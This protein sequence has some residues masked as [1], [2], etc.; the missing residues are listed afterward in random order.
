MPKEAKQ[1]SKLLYILKALYEQTDEQKCLSCSQII[2]YL[3]ENDIIVERKTVISDIACM[4]DFGLDIGV[5]KGKDISGYYL[6]SR[7][8]ELPELKIITEAI[9]SSR[10]ISGKKSKELIGKLSS[11]V[12]PSEKKELSREV[13]VEGRVKTENESL[14]Y[15]VD[16]L[17]T[18]I[19][20]NRQITFVYLIWNRNKELVPK[21]QNRLYRVSPF[22]LT[23]KDDNYYLIAYDYYS[24][25]I[26]HYRVDKM[27]NIDILSKEPREGF[28]E[29]NAFDLGFYTTS[30]FGM[31]AG[32]ND[33]VTV[34]LPEEKIGILL[35]RFGKEIDI[36][37]L[38]DNRVSCRI[39]VS[40]SNQF[41]GWFFGLGP[42]FKIEM[43]KAV[44][45]Q[46][47]EYLQD[48]LATYS[49]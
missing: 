33:T 30:N 22:A 27:K 2:D 48:A 11:L 47:I 36:R 46:Y 42:E 26:R 8:F 5:R 25:Q 3:A 28:E 35:D 23:V 43:P 15:N 21:N 34:S 1:K 17:H 4:K 49:D 24:N 20:D 38:K 45:I 40:V 7:D 32:E 19:R 44:K 6:R 13:F 37:P 14:Y 29:F 16:K 18:A 10:Y 12:G 9:L 31:F 41:F 39:K